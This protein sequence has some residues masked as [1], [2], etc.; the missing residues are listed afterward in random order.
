MELP[1]KDRLFTVGLFSVLD[2]MLDSPMPDVVASMP[3]ADDVAR[4]LLTHEGALG[5]TLHCVL[6]HERGHW[7]DTGSLG[8]DREYIRAAY[9]KALTWASNVGKTVA[10]VSPPGC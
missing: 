10:A 7:S 9:L 8:L 2:A 4:A 1:N 5:R 3:L 6:A